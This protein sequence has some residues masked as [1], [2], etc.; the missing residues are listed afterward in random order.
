MLGAN[1]SGVS[2]STARNDRNYAA[3]ENRPESL[4]GRYTAF[5]HRGPV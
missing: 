4:R 5:V 1:R 3:T 2:H